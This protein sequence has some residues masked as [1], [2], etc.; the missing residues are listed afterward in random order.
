MF[1]SVQE[2]IERRCTN[3]NT[4]IESEYYLGVL[5]MLKDDNDDLCYL[6]MKLT[7]WYSY[8]IVFDGADC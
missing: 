8:R 4:N 2:S 6:C 7:K 5:I 3:A 1:T